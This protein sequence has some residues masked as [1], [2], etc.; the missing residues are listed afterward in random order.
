MNAIL[1]IAGDFLRGA[2]PPQP[3]RVKA[4]GS[5]DLGIEAGQIH[6]YK[7]LNVPRA[8]YEHRIKEANERLADMLSQRSFNFARFEEGF[9]SLTNRPYSPESD[10]LNLAQK[11]PGTFERREKAEAP[12]FGRA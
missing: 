7:N 8:V 1:Q 10:V 5:Y 9:Q 11:C 3:Q 12:V 6:T 4:A 2:R